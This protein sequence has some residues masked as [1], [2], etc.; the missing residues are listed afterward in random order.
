MLGLLS[1]PA[2]SSALTGRIVIAGYGPEQPMMQDLARMYEKLHPGVAVEF[3]W[4]KTVRSTKMVGWRGQIAV[5]D[6]PDADPRPCCRLGWDSI[7]VIARS[8]HRSPRQ[9]AKSVFVAINEVANSRCDHRLDSLRDRKGLH[10]RIEA[11][12]PKGH[13]ADYCPSD[14]QS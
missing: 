5:T 14:H 4:E 13:V 8:N 12:L 6:R 3:Q 11:P 1:V 10:G 2:G 7:I 9:M